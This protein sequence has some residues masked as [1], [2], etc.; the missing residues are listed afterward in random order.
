MIIITPTTTTNNYRYSV[1]E[2]TSGRIIKRDQVLHTG[3]HYILVGYPI[4]E[5]KITISISSA[6]INEDFTIRLNYF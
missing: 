6:S 4:F 3:E 5:D 1:T 2:Y